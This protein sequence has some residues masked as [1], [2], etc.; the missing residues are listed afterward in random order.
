ML[1]TKVLHI[2][3]LLPILVVLSSTPCYLNQSIITPFDFATTP[4]GLTAHENSDKVLYQESH[5]L[6]IGASN[7]I[8]GWPVLPGVM[9]D[10]TAIR[11]A[12]ERKGFTVD[13]VLDPDSTDLNL[14]FEDFIA[15]HGFQEHN[16]LLFYFAGH[17]HTFQPAWGGDPRGY[18]VPVDAPSPDDHPRQFRRKALSM[19]RIEEFALEINAKHALFVFDS[20]F[21]GSLFALTRAIP[22]HIGYKTALPVRQFITSGAEDEQV[23]DNSLFRKQFIRSLNGEADDNNDGYVTGSE[24]SAFLQRSVSN[25]SK[26]SQ[27]P[28]YGKIRNPQLDKGDFVFQVFH[29]ETTSAQN[30][31]VNNVV[32]GMNG[33]LPIGESNHHSGEEVDI[34]AMVAELANRFR[35]NTFRVTTQGDHWSSIV[36]VTSV[37]LEL[38]SPEDLKTEC[39]FI[40]AQA[41]DFLQQ[42]GRY[43]FV[44]RELLKKLLAELQLSSS[45]LVAPGTA[46]RL[47]QVLAADL[48][49]TGSAV[50]KNGQWLINLRFID[51]ETTAILSSIS[52]LAEDENIEIIAEKLGKEVAS[53]LNRTLP[54]QGRVSRISDTLIAMDI[55]SDSGVTE[56][57]I[58][59]LLDA[60][61]VVLA[62]VQALNVR[63][64]KSEMRFFDQ[65]PMNITVGTRLREKT[66]ADQ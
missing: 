15:E 38:R 17:G 11:N 51:V 27:H 57:M 2:F 10:V 5:A 29:G 18:I 49:S 6:I 28:Q 4:P 44:E 1:H 3:C 64:G 54:L 25:Y 14:A 59:E 36:P 40:L 31:P 43:R 39:D 55:G 30:R 60:E 61:G 52:L 24:M 56:G 65:I 32:P 34:D 47:G 22:E 48:I 63:E 7:Y 12:L 35:K 13:T 20:C 41:A 9:K 50:K 23:R 8:E 21:S 45:E 53:E 46:L 19:Q 66:G 33:L 58:F 62:A 16:R 26:G 42:D 37:F